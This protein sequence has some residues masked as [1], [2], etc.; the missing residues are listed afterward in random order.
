MRR[1]KQPKAGDDK[2]ITIGKEKDIEESEPEMK[3]ADSVVAKESQDK[4]TAKDESHKTEDKAVAVGRLIPAIPRK[5]SSPPAA[6]I[7]YVVSVANCDEE[8]AVLRDS[9]LVLQYSIYL[10]S[11]R[12]PASGSKYDYKMYALIHS[13][14]ANCAARPLEEIGFNVKVTG[15]PVRPR[16]K[17][18]LFRT[19]SAE[20]AGIQD[21][22]EFIQ[23]GAFVIPE[24]PI[25]VLT[26]TS[27]VFYKPLDDLFDAML[28]EKDTDDAKAA[29]ANIPLERPDDTLPDKIDA[30]LT[31]NYTFLEPGLSPPLPKWAVGD[32]TQFGC[33][34]SGN[35]S[36]R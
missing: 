1:K 22:N 24:E 16:R 27:S 13:D 34:E 7:A 30:F 11:I 18:M 5:D 12:N 25:V 4:A 8:V 10:Q 23:L 19:K 21:R 35:K 15:S 9:A 26:D 2:A 36:H 32:S 33:S 14:A 28:L 31:R 17:T 6:T 3:E 29:R 20:K